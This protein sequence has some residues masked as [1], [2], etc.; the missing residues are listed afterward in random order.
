MAAPMLWTL[1][2]AAVALALPYLPV[3]AWLGFVPLHPPLLLAL[4]TMTTAYMAITEWQKRWLWR[5]S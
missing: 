1:A 2:V 5:R 4:L 3:G